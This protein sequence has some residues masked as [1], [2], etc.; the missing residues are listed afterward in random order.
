[1]RVNS[2]VME[3][4]IAH[5]D[6]D[7]FYAA[8]E[9]LDDPALDG[10]PVIVG[11]T[12]K[13]GVVSS[14]SYEA[15]AYG[16]RSAM[17][18][19][20]AKRLCPPGIFIHPRMERYVE[21]SR[22]VME[23]L[24]TFT[25]EMEQVSVDEAYLD[26]TGTSRLYGPPR[27]TGLR[28][29]RLIREGVGLV[30]SVGL[31]PNR[32]IAKIASDFDKPDGLVVVP[33]EEASRFLA[34]LP[35]R[36]LP[37]VGPRLAERLRSVG[38]DRVADLR[39]FSQEELTRI[40]GSMGER[41]FE[42]ARG[43]DDT[44]LHRPAKSKSISAEQTL[45]RDTADKEVLVP[46]LAA[47]ALRVSRRLRREGF[48][49]RTVVLKLK[50]SDFK[51]VTRSRS[52]DRAVDETGVIFRAGLDL[53]HDYRLKTSVRLIGLGLTNL[54]EPGFSQG[55]LFPPPEGGRRR[56]RVD[57]ALDDIL[58]RFGS[59]AIKLGVSLKKE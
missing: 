36:R 41:L 19:F 15:R 45:E 47:Q 58:G 13:R 56:G 53:L 9:A 18:T 50:H 7:C 49:A 33:P 59:Q 54:E 17:P 37:G 8:V 38:V 57:R 30:C 24:R 29:K 28:L 2:E 51:Q 21:I 31:A 34:P 43:I 1:M 40:F 32:L 55:S 3:R 25:P 12:A 4:L 22:G 14:A 35:V 6:M 52:L 27:E 5:L 44:P 42:T 16:V 20:E 10:R 23:L 39:R 48:L 11:G 26:L 46:L